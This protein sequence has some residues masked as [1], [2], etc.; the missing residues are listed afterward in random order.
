LGT[1]AKYFSFNTPVAAKPE[2][3]CGRGVM[4][5]LHISTEILG[6]TM[7]ADCE[8][9]PLTPQELALEFMLFDLSSCV[10]R[11]DIAPIVPR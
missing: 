1:S 8:M 11:D 7:P 9:N 6:T 4:S 2:D 10:Q 5:D 3:Q